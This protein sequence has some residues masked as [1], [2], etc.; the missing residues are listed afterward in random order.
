MA[1]PGVL[2]II[3]GDVFLYN[4]NCQKIKTYYFK[5]SKGEATR[6]DW[7]VNESVQIQLKDGRI[8]MVNRDCQIYKIYN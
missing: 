1:N 3:N 7:D 5:S 6:A 4:E 2:R 8:I